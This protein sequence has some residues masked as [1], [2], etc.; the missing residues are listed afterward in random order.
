MLQDSNIAYPLM[1]GIVCQVLANSWSFYVI[2]IS[3]QLIYAQLLEQYIQVRCSLPSIITYICSFQ[4][5]DFNFRGHAGSV[6]QLCWHA[7]QP[8]LLSTASGDKTV[9]IW[10]AR[11]QKCAA[12]ITTKGKNFNL[13]FQ[14]SNSLFILL[15]IY[16]RPYMYGLLHFT[17][18]CINFTT[19]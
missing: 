12:T 15:F 6:D 14:K 11:N 3:V 16:C 1:Y 7:S 5:K 13:F 8:E 17:I 10:D 19:A 9:R 2:S 4:S 18:T